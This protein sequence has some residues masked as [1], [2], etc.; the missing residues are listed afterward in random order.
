[1]E[2]IFYSGSSTYLGEYTRKADG[3][4]RSFATASSGERGFR[5]LRKKFK[6]AGKPLWGSACF[7]MQSSGRFNMKFGYEDC[8]ENGDTRFDADEELKR[9]EA[10]HKRLTS[11]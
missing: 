11:E 10:R 3:K 9:A 5:E 6:Q 7:E 4:L 1:M 2:A 8:D